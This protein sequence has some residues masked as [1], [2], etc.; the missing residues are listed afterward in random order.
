MFKNLFKGLTI[1]SVKIVCP[2]CHYVNDTYE[3]YKYESMH[4]IKCN[5]SLNSLV[6]IEVTDQNSLLFIQNNDRPTVLYFYAS[7]CQSCTEM[8]HIYEDLAED[9]GTKFCFLKINRD[10][11]HQLAEHYNIS[12][13]PSL[14]LFHGSDKI[15]RINGPISQSK[16]RYLLHDL[17]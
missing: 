16:L 13:L 17:Y 9:L 6:P 1:D 7:S 8:H 5:A 10:K 15:T 3:E 2:Q 4:C 12:T 14:I 11:Y